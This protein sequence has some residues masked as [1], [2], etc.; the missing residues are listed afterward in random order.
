[1]TSS[2]ESQIRSSE[3]LPLW[4]VMQAAYGGEPTVSGGLAAEIEAVRDLMF[5]EEPD[6]HI[7]NPVAASDLNHWAIQ[8]ALHRQRRES[9]G[10]L[11]EQAQ[12]AREAS[13]GRVA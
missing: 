1:M 4:R 9:R 7:P 12:V 5:P 11:T 8:L 2:N 10:Y 6:L 3:T 13:S